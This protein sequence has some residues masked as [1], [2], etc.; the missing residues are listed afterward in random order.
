MRLLYL[1]SLCL[2]LLTGLKAQDVHLTQFYTSN[3]SLNPAMTGHFDGDMKFTLNSRTQWSEFLK[4]IKTNMLTVEKKFLKRFDEIGVGL[5]VINDVFQPMFLKTNKLNIGIS[6]QKVID[7]NKI[8]VGISGGPV[9]RNIDFDRQQLPDQWNYQA[10]IF[11]PTIATG[12]SNP[13][14]SWGYAD[15]NAGVGYSRRFLSWKVDG[16]YAVFHVNRPNEKFTANSIQVPV[17]HVFSVSVIKNL[18]PDLWLSPHLLYMKSVRA[19]DLL[20]VLK[21]NKQLKKNIVVSGGTAYRGSP[22]NSDAVMAVAGLTYNRFFFG[23][24]R[25]F[26]VS[27]LRKGTNNKAAW[28]LAITYT[29]PSKAPG[30]IT[31][32]CD[33]Y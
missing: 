10:G 3:V 19:T 26:I 13:R 32:P 24:S 5:L 31:V 12:E 2:L 11:D 33:R 9:L 17:R 4:S 18:R 16:G 29:T 8:R 25:D 30:K 28:E 6:Y 27:N 20:L 14:G 1:T 21:A 23:L 15:L 7:K 22:V